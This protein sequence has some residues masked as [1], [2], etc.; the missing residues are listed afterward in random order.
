[1]KLDEI[2]IEEDEY[3]EARK[4]DVRGRAYLFTAGL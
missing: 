1:M 4:R 3:Q 2:L